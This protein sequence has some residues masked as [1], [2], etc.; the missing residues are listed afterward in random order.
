M[1]TGPPD[2]ATEDLVARARQ[3]RGD[4][5]LDEAEVT[6]RVAG[7]RSGETS[8]GA[9]YELAVLLERQR[10]TAEAHPVLRAL[11]CRGRGGEA[12]LRR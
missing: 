9:L 6:Y 11:T 8:A 5:G 3:L 1:T 12:V 7:E 2:E 10:R 4:S